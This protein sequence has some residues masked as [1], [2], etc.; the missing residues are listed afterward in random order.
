ML[1]RS[2]DSPVLGTFSC[3]ASRGGGLQGVGKIEREEKRER[4]RER[5]RTDVYMKRTYNMLK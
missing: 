5:E 3:V 4:E 2:F 1:T